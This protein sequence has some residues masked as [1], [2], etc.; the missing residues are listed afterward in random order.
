MVLRTLCL[1]GEL[2]RGHGYTLWRFMNLPNW[3]TVGRILLVPVFL[4]LAYRHSAA[5]TGVALFVFVLASASDSVDGRLARRRGQTTRAGIFLDPLADKLLLGAALVVLVGQRDFPLWAALVIGFR[6]I[7]VQIL[8]TQI[9]RGGGDLPASPA[10]K[11]KTLLQGVMVGW[12]LLP[13]EPNVG[14]WLLLGLVLI[15]TLWS[16]GE[17]FLRAQSVGKVAG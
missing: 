3:I 14:H 2:T 17:Y 16:G 7:A 4:L 10:G 11:S 15:A 12:W 8:R 1:A 13:W 5:T 6:E 9:V